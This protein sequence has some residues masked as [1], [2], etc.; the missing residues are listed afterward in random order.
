MSEKHPEDPHIRAFFM[1]VRLSEIM[2]REV[3][4][5]FDDDPFSLVEEKMRENCI[6]HLPVVDFQKKLVGIITQ[7][8]LYRTHTPRKDEDG[9]WFYDKESLNEHV[10]KDAMTKSPVS[11]SPDDF[12]GTAVMLMVDNKY[13]CIPL[14][15][16]DGKLVG[17][18]T[19]HD[20][21][22]IPAGILRE[23]GKGEGK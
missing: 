20:I 19:Q 2:I 4:S 6:R 18:V 21:L 15:D 10:L 9:N 14:V 16:D 23:S 22:K 1:K 3:I 13:G 8:D 7:R 17:I 12:L 11:L 5:L